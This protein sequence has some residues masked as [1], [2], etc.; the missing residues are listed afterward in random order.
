MEPAR[1]DCCGPKAVAATGRAYMFQGHLLHDPHAASHP[2][3]RCLVAGEKGEPLIQKVTLRD[4]CRIHDQARTDDRRVRIDDVPA[5]RTGHSRGWWAEQFVPP[6]TV[7]DAGPAVGLGQWREPGRR[8]H[9]SSAHRRAVP[10]SH[11]GHVA[12]SRS[13]ADHH[14]ASG[15]DLLHHP[16]PR[17]P[18]LFGIVHSDRASAGVLMALPARWIHEQQSVGQGAR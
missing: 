8:I 1:P 6:L 7:V 18:P 4:R 16:R 3:R 9:Q 11:F 15:V 14:L 13:G 17:R 2:G 12:L 10:L 5:G